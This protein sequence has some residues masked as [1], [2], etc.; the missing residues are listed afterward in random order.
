MD[1]KRNSDFF[2]NSV[3]KSA[4][5]LKIIGIVACLVGAIFML[6][7]FSNRS[8]MKLQL[9]PI[10]LVIGGI[11]FYFWGQSKVVKEE[12]LTDVLDIKLKQ[13]EDVVY[14]IFNYP[15][16]YKK[17]TKG[18][19]GCVYT[20]TPGV[21]RQLMNKEYMS[22]DCVVT[23]V[24]YTTE[25]RKVGVFIYTREFSMLSEAQTD[26]QKL[27]KF[28]DFDD[29]GVGHIELEEGRR[30]TTVCFYKE[31]EKIFEFPVMN[32]D[33]YSEEFFADLLHARKRFLK[34]KF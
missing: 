17:Q 7:V 9:V 11:V 10:V 13:V 15:A 23:Q 22:P 33:Y 29:A 24:Y 21:V 30:A 8:L 32:S 31:G 28:E 5:V 19:V 2:Q 12:E 1:Y 27:L 3:A 16:N 6:L 14:E 20:K 26:S 25:G 18:F 34:I 4:K